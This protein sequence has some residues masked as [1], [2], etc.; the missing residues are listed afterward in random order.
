MP[1]GPI[2]EYTVKIEPQI[3]TWMKPRVFQLLEYSPAFNPYIMYIAHDGKARMVA[4]RELPQPL[5]IPIVF[6]GEGMSV[7][8][9]N[10]TYIVT[11]KSN[12]QLETSGLQK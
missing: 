1:K 11:I 12:G 8:A 9:N 4:A 6:F 10:K 5:M 2:Y 7:K 3:S